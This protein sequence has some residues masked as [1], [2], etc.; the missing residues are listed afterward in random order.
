MNLL[1]SCIDSVEAEL[2]LEALKPQG[3]RSQDKVR[4]LFE[5]PTLELLFLA[6]MAA[7]HGAGGY[8]VRAVIEAGL[9]CGPELRLLANL[10]RRRNLMLLAAL[11][12]AVGALT[13]AG[14]RCLSFKGPLLSLVL[15]GD[16][17]IRPSND[18]DVLVPAADRDHALAVLAGIGFELETQI[19]P[20]AAAAPR[21]TSE[22]TGLIRGGV[23]LELHHKIIGVVESTT[24]FDTAWS[25]REEQ[26]VAGVRVAI[27]GL[28]GRTFHLAVHGARHHFTCLKWL[29][30]LGVLAEQDGID[31][32]WQL[33]EAQRRGSKRA[34]LQGWHHAQQFLS[35][36]LPTA[37]AGPIRKEQSFLEGAAERSQRL[38]FPVVNNTGERLDLRLFGH[39]LL[40]EPVHRRVK[41]VCR[42]LFIPTITDFDYHPSI[43][44]KT[45]LVFSFLRPLRLI[46]RTG[47]VL[48]ADFKSRAA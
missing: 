31:W 42:M 16:S 4:A 28:A 13:A 47:R 2:L 17:G 25:R 43:P 11:A 5:S 24:E 3:S 15:H 21:P 20:R 29:A 41:T 12:E 40:L 46:R 35:V 45:P 7:D 33:S 8:V 38:W 22:H 48:F 14:V 34:F 9:D 32:E 30:D 23:H 18:I 39:R 36:S 1:N 44:P 6:Q 26:D 10:V 37:L 19:D 27:L